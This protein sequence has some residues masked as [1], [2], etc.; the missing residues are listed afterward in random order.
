MSDIKIKGLDK[1]QKELKDN[2]TMDDVKMVVKMNGTR[3]TQTMKAMTTTAYTKGYTIGDTAGSINMELRD[4]GF[5]VAVG[6]SMDYDLYVEYGT[7]FMQAEPII[8]PTMARVE[9]KFRRDMERLKK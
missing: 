9:P 8:E 6:A 4:D 1:L 3:L 2:V 7:R 5:T